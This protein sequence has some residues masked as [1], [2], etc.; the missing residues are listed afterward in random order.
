M[1]TA[2]SHAIVFV[3]RNNFFKKNFSLKKV[4]LIKK[5]NFLKSFIMF[6]NGCVWPLRARFKARFEFEFFFF[7]FEGKMVARMG[8]SSKVSQLHT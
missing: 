8:F 5:N 6:T 1:P 3:Y 2:N 4:F 7:C